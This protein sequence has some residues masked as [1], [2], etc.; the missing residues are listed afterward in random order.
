MTTSILRCP[1]QPFPAAVPG[2]SCFQLHLGRCRGLESLFG[3]V[4]E[5][6]RG[7]LHMGLW[8]SQLGQVEQ[9]SPLR[10]S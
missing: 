4:T 5:K 7:E 2:S 1:G 9:V 3:R 8:P 6:G 10:K